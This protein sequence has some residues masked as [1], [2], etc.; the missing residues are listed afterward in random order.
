MLPGRLSGL[1]HFSSSVSS[2]DSRETSLNLE[3]FPEGFVECF[4]KC[5]LECFPDG[6]PEY[7]PRGFLE[8]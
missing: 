7:F 6:F 4:P 2:N 8:A 5:F 3:G 1:P